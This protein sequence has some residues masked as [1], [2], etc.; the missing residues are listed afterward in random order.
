MAESSSILFSSSCTSE[1]HVHWCMYMCVRDTVIYVALLIVVCT[2]YAFKTRKIPENFNESKFIGF[3][4]YTV[5]APTLCI[6]FGYY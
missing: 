2:F 1:P 5:R 4:M 3:T 6:S